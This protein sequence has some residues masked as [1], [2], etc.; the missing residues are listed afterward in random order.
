MEDEIP[1]GFYTAKVVNAKIGKSDFNRG[2][3]TICYVLLAFAITDWR[4][5]DRI[6]EWKG[7]ITKGGFRRTA[8]VLHTCGARMEDDDFSD[9]HGIDKRTVEI[10][11]KT[12]ECFEAPGTF[13]T[14]V[15]RIKPCS[16]IERT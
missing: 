16:S 1:D 6:F 14:F 5:V 15:R 7:P 11:L 9:F 2:E 8:E 12:I 13:R 3:T 4:Y 10:E